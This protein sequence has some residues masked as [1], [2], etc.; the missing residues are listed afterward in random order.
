VSPFSKHL[1]KISYLRPL[2]PIVAKYPSYRSYTTYPPTHFQ[3]SNFQ[4]QIVESAQSALYGHMCRP[5]PAGA[6]SRSAAR[7]NLNPNP[8]ILYPIRPRRGRTLFAP[9][10]GRQNFH[11]RPETSDKRPITQSHGDHRVYSYINICSLCP[12]CSLCEQE[13]NP[14]HPVNPV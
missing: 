9:L 8:Y 2:S 10:Q 6:S 14:V 12:L 5:S 13:L 4:F 11:Q 3:I 7:G 1:L